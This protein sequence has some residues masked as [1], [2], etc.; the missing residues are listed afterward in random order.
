M[1]HLPVPTE[2]EDKE[3]VHLPVPTEAED[4]KTK[5]YSHTNEVNRT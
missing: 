2:A 4:K 3:M 5:I 1:V